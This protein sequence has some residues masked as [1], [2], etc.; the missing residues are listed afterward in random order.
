[1]DKLRIAYIGNWHAQWKTEEGVARGFESLGHSVT[2]IGV[3]NDHDSILATVKELRPDILLG[4][5]WGFRGAEQMDTNGAG[6][7]CKLINA[8]RPFIGAAVTWHWDLVAPEF[9]PER[10]AWQQIVSEACDLTALTDGF[11]A[12]RLPKC[13]V[14][15]DGA[16]DDVDDSVPF[17]PI[18]ECLF[19][20]SLYRDRGAWWQAMRERLG[21]RIVH[22]GQGSDGFEPLGI[23]P[24]ELVTGPKLTKLVRSFRICVQPPWPFFPGYASDR[25]VVLRAHGA[26]LAAPEVPGYGD[27]LTHDHYLVTGTR[28]DSQA[29]KVAEYLDRHDRGQLEA[30]RRAGMAHARSKTWASRVEQLLSHLG[31]RATSTSDTGAENSGSLADEDTVLDSSAEIT[32]SQTPVEISSRSSSDD[33]GA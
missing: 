14:I 11:A 8:C 2:R 25:S 19:V 20:G 29:N 3:D 22:V 6:S 13:V 9:A 7:V 18:G 33:S 16:P 27:G 24:G 31:Q 5:K 30:I 23:S 28:P 4:A 1:M 12:P 17:E 26:L 21:S 10:F 15:R 32:H